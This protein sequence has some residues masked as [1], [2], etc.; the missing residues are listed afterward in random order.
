MS[1]FNEQNKLESK[2]LYCFEQFDVIGDGKIFVNQVGDV[3]RAMGENP[4]NH[5]LN[6]LLDGLQEK[7]RIDF[8]AF[9][10]ILYSVRKSPNGYEC[11]DYLEVFS[12]FDRGD[13]KSIHNTVVRHILTTHGEKLDES[14]VSD[15]L[16]NLEDS[17]GM[18]NYEQLVAK[19]LEKPIEKY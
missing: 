6:K 7:D 14:E 12:T 10:P 16:Q 19:I 8:E 1:N 15:I 9:L 18:I 5:L 17:H 13:A 3:V 11:E 4:P 2:L